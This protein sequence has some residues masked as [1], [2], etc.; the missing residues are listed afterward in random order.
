[1]QTWGRLL[2]GKDKRWIGLGK[3]MNTRYCGDSWASFHKEKIKL[4]IV[5]HD[6]DKDK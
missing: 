4:D 2:L 6:K 3:L 5:K 1:M